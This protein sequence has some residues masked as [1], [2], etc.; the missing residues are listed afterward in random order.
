MQHRLRDF[1]E[2]LGSFMHNIMNL[3]ILNPGRYAGFDEIQLTGELAFTLAHASGP[4]FKDTNNVNNGPVGVYV[5]PQGMIIM[6]TDAIPGFAVETN[7]G[8]SSERY[9]LL[10]ANHQYL[11][12]EGGDAATYSIIKGPIG[13]TALPALTNP[14]F[15]T[16][17][18][19]LKLRRLGINPFELNEPLVEWIKAKAPSVGDSP[20]ARLDE[21][22]VYT[23]LQQFKSTDHSLSNLGEPGD[24]FTLPNSGNSI[25]IQGTNSE[26]HRKVKGWRFKDIGP[27]Q[28]GTEISMYVDKNLHFMQAPISNEAIALGYRPLFI[29]AIFKTGTIDGVPSASFDK[30]K[31]AIVRF[32]K[33]S[34]TWYLESVQRFGGVIEG[35][36]ED[37]NIPNQGFKIHYA[38]SVYLG[39]APDATD[40]L[41]PITFS[42][43]DTPAFPAFP[44]NVTDAAFIQIIGNVRSIGTDWNKDN[45]VI[46]AIRDKT[47][48]GF[49]LAFREVSNNVQNLRFDFIVTIMA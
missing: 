22:N 1:K 6:E 44:V 3:G 45:D 7:A 19:I 23:S 20:T 18:G 12:N 4:I 2:P 34:D 30:N 11:E 41:V 16:V 32:I 39:D 27:G 43:L 15:Q 9:D 21:T 17:I 31:P 10:V 33:F 14:S 28:S 37:A 5:T 35:T 25:R 48:E 42:L 24:C 36:D 46:F 49:K 26:G 29:P 8:N 47:L 38:G 40:E 13:S